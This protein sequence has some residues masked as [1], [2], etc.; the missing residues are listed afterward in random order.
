MKR[1]LPNTYWV[2][3]GRF[4]AGEF[5]GGVTEGESRKRL[6]RLLDAGIDSFIDL[7]E[8][9]ERDPYRALLPREVDYYQR[10]LPDHGVPADPNAINEVLAVLRKALGAGRRVYLHCRAGIGRT[11][12][13]V[14]CHLRERDGL[15]G[16]LALARLNELWQQNARAR[17]WPRV[18]ETEAQADFVRAW[19]PGGT[20]G[21]TTTA[22]ATATTSSRLPALGHQD[23]PQDRRARARGSLL[24]LAIG[25]ALAVPLQG[26]PA[27]TPV[28]T[29]FAGGGPDAL[30]PGA[31]TDET[32]MA[33]CQADSLIAC[34][35]VDTRDQ[36][37]RYL[38]WLREGHRSATGVAAGVRPE[39]RR[40]LG[41]A[42]A[43]HSAL[44][45]VHDPRVLDAEPLARCA[46]AAIFYDDLEAAT[47]AGADAARITHQAPVLVDACRLFTA[48]VHGAL[49]GADRPALLAHALEWD[50]ILKP[51]VIAV[52]GGWSA[53]AGAAHRRP[54]GAI[55]ATLDAVVRAFAQA[56]DFR[57]GL[58][59]VLAQPAG[60]AEPDVAAAAYGQ[61]AG[62]WFGERL[63]PPPWRS[64]LLGA[65]GIVAV[66]DALAAGGTGTD[67]L[68]PSGAV[69]QGRQSR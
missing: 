51:E 44:T 8:P 6:A 59:A 24:G 52:A 2:V 28:P 25:D 58:L 64:R 63:L 47:E 57:T 45:G 1:P 15:D 43:R 18:P 9:H 12:M 56:A 65:D 19:H 53:P 41:L 26:A 42:A 31:W 49:A 21:P 16:E 4:L 14:A 33:L 36:A 3:D 32:A 37:E 54:R 40:L 68:S 7:T 46:P 29:D 38:H 30:P 20:A 66:A 48:L 27:G 34:R 11:G 69:P 17:Q 50:G 10:P 55:L 39:L 22:V 67:A 23:P 62:A 35:G 5:P 60:R 13:T 61:L